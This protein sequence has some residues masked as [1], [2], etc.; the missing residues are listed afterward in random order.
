MA[1]LFVTRQKTVKNGSLCGK[2]VIRVHVWG[3]FWDPNERIF[4]A[5]AFIAATFLTR[6]SCALVWTHFKRHCNDCEMKSFLL[7]AASKICLLLS[8]SSSKKHYRYRI[9]MRFEMLGSRLHVASTFYIRQGLAG[10]TVW[11]YHIPAHG[12]IWA[13][14]W[15]T[16]L[17]PTLAGGASLT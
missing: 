14:K 15:W 11:G 2:R 9:Q 4:V 6:L 10:R 7:S 16:S 3:I 17:F 13:L 5:I 1:N 12:E 8:S